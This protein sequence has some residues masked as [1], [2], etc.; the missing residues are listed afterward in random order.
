MTLSPKASGRESGAGLA[1]SFAENW[2]TTYDMPGVGT[3]WGKGIENKLLAKNSP[4]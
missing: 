3:P 2:G 4:V 1:T